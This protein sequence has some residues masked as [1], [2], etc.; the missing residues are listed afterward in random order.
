MM[1][2]RA[3]STPDTGLELT[4]NNSEP[5]Q[6]KPRESRHG[7]KSV[8]IKKSKSSKSSS[9]SRRSK[10]KQHID[11]KKEEPRSRKK[12]HNKIKRT[13]SCTNL[14]SKRRTSKRSS[15]ANRSN[16][17]RSDKINPSEPCYVIQ[18]HF[19]NDLL[20]IHVYDS[21]STNEWRQE[22]T[23][24]A[25]KHINIS[26]AAKML[27]DSINNTGK[28]NNDDGKKKDYK[29]NYKIKI[30]EYNGF[31]Y[32][33]LI[34]SR[35]PS[36]ALRPIP[37]QK[38]NGNMSELKEENEQF[39]C[40]DD[41]G[42]VSPPIDPIEI[43]MQKPPSLHGITVNN[44]IQ[45]TS[46]KQSKSKLLPVI[47]NDN[48][49]KR[50]ST[51]NINDG[52]QYHHQR[53]HT[54]SVHISP[55][56][57]AIINNDKT[58]E[59]V[60]AR[61]H[62]LNAAQSKSP[63]FFHQPPPSFPMNNKFTI[64]LNGNQLAST[65][66]HLKGNANNNQT[67][68]N[69]HHHNHNYYSMNNISMNNSP[70][71]QI[72]KWSN[73]GNFG[74]YNANNVHKDNHEFNGYRYRKESNDTLY[75]NT[76]WISSSPSAHSNA[77]YNSGITSISVDSNSTL[78]PSAVLLSPLSPSTN[79]KSNKRQGPGFDDDDDGDEDNPVIII[80]KHHHHKKS[81]SDTFINGDYYNSRSMAD[82]E[83]IKYDYV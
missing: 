9:K 52:N 73:P 21:S 43:M 60:Y 62:M 24:T 82:K 15:S 58:K 37:Q 8:T 72:K 59:L 64:T 36:F 54:H 11:S 55:R 12:R 13:Q 1:F 3:K 66:S 5:R 74:G 41:D 33:T 2:H 69:I 7:R 26:K 44:M 20:K 68:T 40:S 23:Q 14:S 22:F 76:S 35:L 16:P 28:D 80:H 71:Q 79:N 77:G 53:G 46:S 29:Y 42:S 61:H 30:F 10:K 6:Y 25:F 38:Y 31:C 83:N 47:I 70:K 49:R 67:N 18:A 17:K 27:T 45:S 75:S 50:H 19:K 63:P 48:G 39:D 34:D 81:L 32:C 51:G 57:M 56:R 65:Q 78:S 4:D